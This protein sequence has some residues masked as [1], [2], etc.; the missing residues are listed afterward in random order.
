MQ[1]CLPQWVFNLCTCYTSKSYFNILTFNTS[2]SLIDVSETSACFFSLQ[3]SWMWR[4]SLSRT[5][6]V[7]PL[8]ARAP[9]NYTQDSASC[10]WWFVLLHIALHVVIELGH[11][12][13][14]KWF[15]R[16]LS[17]LLPAYMSGYF[18]CI[19]WDHGCPWN[20]KRSDS[21]WENR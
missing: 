17:T 13:E 11:A 10:T 4:W 3:K 16:N 7:L 1:C 5:F 12:L 6:F 19:F 15:V 14:N 20:F 21:I 2:N 8:C 9:L 18:P